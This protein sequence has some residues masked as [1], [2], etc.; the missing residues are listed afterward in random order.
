MLVFV[1]MGIVTSMTTLVT[2][3]VAS[4]VAS[5]SRAP[6]YLALKCIPKEEA[7]FYWPFNFLDHW[8]SE[9]SPPFTTSRLAMNNLP[10]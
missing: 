10:S 7:F 8:A 9:S 4:E 1:Y 6:L 5:G 3:D 2:R